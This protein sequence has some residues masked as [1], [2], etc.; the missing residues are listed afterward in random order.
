MISNSSEDKPLEVEVS[1]KKV[2]KKEEPENKELS[3][4]EIKE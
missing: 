3:A 2:E 4:I 1:G